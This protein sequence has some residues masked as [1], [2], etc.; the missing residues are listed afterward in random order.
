MKAAVINNDKVEIQEIE[1]PTLKEKGAIIEVSGSGLC[2]SDIIK[3]LH[4]QN[5]IVIGH[6]IVGKI[7]E[8]ESDTDFKKGDFIVMG[9]HVPCYKCS[10]CKGGSFSMCHQFKETNIK[11]GGFAQYI[12][13]SELH[14]KNTVHK[15]PNELTE[16]EASFMEPLGCC[17][18]AIERAELPPNSTV[19][20]IGLGSI[21]IL[22]GQGLKAYGHKVTGID[23][24]QERLDLAKKFGFDNVIKYSDEETVKKEISD[25]KSTGA[26]AVF[27]TAGA[28]ASIE[29]A[30]NCV[31]NGGT[32]VVFSS[33][34]DDNIGFSNNDIYYR[35]LKILSTYSATPET[36][37]K[38]LELLK[39]EKVRVDN[40][41]VEYKLDDLQKAIDDTL[42][43]KIMKAYIRIKT[44]D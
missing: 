42:S 31:R 22:M 35:E 15:V 43:N 32:I 34:S 7:I 18:R 30:Q 21:G 39:D 10:F 8:I 6:E 28:K 23:L 29:T 37:S 38:S 36:L 20:V 16:I 24:L 1:R 26:D 41:S 11:P 4:K 2:G 9:H 19:A 14:L 12:F 33:V 27:L 3:Y 44:N 25:I 17:I 5:G 40:L 13:A